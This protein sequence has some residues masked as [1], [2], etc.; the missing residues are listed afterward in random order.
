MG[1]NGD[2]NTQLALAILQ[3]RDF[4][5]EFINDNNIL[6][7]IFAGEKWDEKTNELLLDEDIYSVEKEK[8]TREVKTGKSPKLV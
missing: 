8:W 3:S 1:G 5:T 6:V 7:P 2:N 4:L